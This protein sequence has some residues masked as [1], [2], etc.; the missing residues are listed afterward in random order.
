MPVV[1]IR[2]LFV[3]LMVA[4]VIYETNDIPTFSPAMH[5]LIARYQMDFKLLG[6]AHGQEVYLYTRQPPPAAP[7]KDVDGRRAL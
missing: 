7:P 3:A 1:V 4:I 5:A 6:K 2:G